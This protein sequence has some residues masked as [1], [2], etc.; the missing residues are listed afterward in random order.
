MSC[1]IEVVSGF[2]DETLGRLVEVAVG[3]EFGLGNALVPDEVIS[4]GTL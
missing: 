2:A 3:E 1:V 4:G